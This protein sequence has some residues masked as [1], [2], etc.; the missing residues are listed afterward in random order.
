MECVCQ[1]VP[2]VQKDFNAGCVS[3][4][5]WFALGQNSSTDL[6]GAVTC[7]AGARERGGRLRLHQGLARAGS[8][9]Q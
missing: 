6:A 1:P 5:T 7:Q 8:P 2:I 3:A 9:Q 4:A